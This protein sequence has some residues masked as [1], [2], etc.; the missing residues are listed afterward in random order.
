MSGPHPHARASMLASPCPAPSALPALCLPQQGWSLDGPSPQ[1]VQS[2]RPVIPIRQEFAAGPRNN[3][4]GHTHTQLS[5]TH[6]QLRQSSGI[7]YGSPGPPGLQHSK[8]PGLIAPSQSF[9]PPH[10]ALPPHPPAIPQSG[11]VHPPM[12]DPHASREFASLSSE[13]W[14]KGSSLLLPSF[15]LPSHHRFGAPMGPKSWEGERQLRPLLPDPNRFPSGFS[16]HIGGSIIEPRPLMSR[17]QLHSNL[18]EANLQQFKLSAGAYEM[19]PRGQSR[20]LFQGKA[21]L[22]S[23]CRTGT[24]F[25]SSF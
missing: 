9:P 10:V 3:Q 21:L 2:S 18:P 20:P 17:E 14:Q 4:F 6:S 7:Q 12:A 24:P 13:P 15:G 23:I 1:D 8:P 25:F 22:F 19:V 11:H 16:S 5:H